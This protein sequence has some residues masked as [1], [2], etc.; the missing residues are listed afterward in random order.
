[1]LLL[2][3]PQAA[4]HLL[5]LL[6]WQVLSQALHAMLFSMLAATRLLV[7]RLG[8]QQT[9]LLLVVWGLTQLP[10]QLGPSL[11]LLLLSMQL[12]C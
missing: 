3:A 7:V 5:L 11:L 1:M 10:L 4:R 9:R 2:C 8:P 12:M 6:L